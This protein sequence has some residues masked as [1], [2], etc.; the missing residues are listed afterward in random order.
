MS[1]MLD[2]WTLADG[3]REVAESRRALEHLREERKRLYAAWEAENA[4]LLLQEKATAE[5]LAAA[6]QNLRDA[7]LREYEQTSN[8]TPAPG[9][10][11]RVERTYNYAPADALDW[12]KQHGMALALDAKAFKDI[13]KADSTRPGFVFVS[14]EPK[15]LIATDLSAALAEVAA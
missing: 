4:P 8:K 10:S 3:V 14:D 7:V 6:E 13:C 12:A 2:A 5:A 1:T 15:A 11:V 9:L